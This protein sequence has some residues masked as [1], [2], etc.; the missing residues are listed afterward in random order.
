MG[1]EESG[2]SIL[3]EPAALAPDV[4]HVA[5]VH[6]PVQHRRG[7]DGVAEQLTPLAEASIRRQDD[8]SLLVPGRDQ[9]KER[10]GRVPVVLST[11]GSTCP[12]SGTMIRPWGETD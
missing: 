12:E 4:E 10:G 6:Q 1:A 7:D 2:L 5:V 8:G 3:P 9:G 11:G